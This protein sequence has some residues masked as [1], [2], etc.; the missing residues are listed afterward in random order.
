M[1]LLTHSL[2]TAFRNVIITTY[3]TEDS[4]ALSYIAR[5]RQLFKFDF[6]IK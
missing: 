3:F 5:I 6:L 1:I 2:L 4:S